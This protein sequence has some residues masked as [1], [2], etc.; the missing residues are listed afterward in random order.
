[1][2]LKLFF[3]L[4]EKWSLTREDQLILLGQNSRSTL[5]NWERKIGNNEDISLRS[6]TL[7]RLSLIAGIRKGVELLYPQNRWDDYMREPNT[8]FGDVSLLDVMLKGTV[9]ALYDARR[10]L[11]A[12]RGAHFG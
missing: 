8:E 12:S 11:D 2:G 5:N 4:S 6:D 9:G 7:E 3:A 10:Y 1:M